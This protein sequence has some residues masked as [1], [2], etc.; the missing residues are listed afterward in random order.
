MIYPRPVS[1]ASRRRP[2]QIEHLESRQLLAADCALPPGFVSTLDAPI[3]PAETISVANAEPGSNRATAL[4]LGIVNETVTL[5]D[6]VSFRDRL[7]VFRFEISRDGTAEIDLSR[8]RRNADLLL[9]DASG[10]ALESARSRGRASESISAEL[11][12]GVYYV[13]V[14]KRSFRGTL[15]RLDIDVTLG[16]AAPV[17]VN[18][19]TPGGG[20]STE[21][22]PTETNPPSATP[23]GGSTSPLSDAA[24]FG[25]SREWNVNAVNAPEAWQAG[26]TG[27]GVTIAVVDTGVDL[28]H[29]DL[30]DRLYVN[31]GEI[32][33]NGIDDDG[34]GFI[35]DVHGFDFAGRDGDPND[36]GGHGTHVAGSIAAGRN[37]FGAT[38][39][40]PD[41]TILPVRVLG[42]NGSGSTRDVAAGIRYAADR[43]ADIINLSL[44]GGYSR[45][46]QS[47]I[48]YARSLGAFIVAAAGNESA[49]TP[50]Y[51]ARFS[52][53]YDNVISVGAHDQSNR[54]ARF[55]N[56]VGGSGA[57]QIDGPGVGVFSTYVGA[58]YGSLSGTSMAAPH[59]AGVA[60]LAL[61]ANPNL[62]PDQLRG[63]LVAGAT[64]SATGSD[65]VGIVN[66]ATTVAYAAAGLTSPPVAVASTSDVSGLSG[67]NA[68]YYRV[69]SQP[70]LIVSATRLSESTSDNESNPIL[71]ESAVMDSTGSEK[72]SSYAASTKTNSPTAI[73]LALHDLQHEAD[74]DSDLVDR[75]L[76]SLSSPIS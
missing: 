48:E 68:R 31:A 46:I 59:V 45:A 39:I 53:L 70:A 58:R 21:T 14:Q 73:D 15:Y 36:V 43:G 62:T 22:D 64:A 4:D 16:S 11:E 74:S 40:A 17:I 67:A 25:G 8:L 61:S 54:L 28:D 19:T 5:T 18:P 3:A 49:G 23:S 26:F 35:D 1:C 50:G 44:G 76:S 6:R 69:I 29:P 12:S 9:F 42:A 51:P 47:A 63:L 27:Q 57:V 7:D 34:N 20:G 71:I 66:A 24:Y 56:D 2:I 33:G 41:A 37:G 75:A 60:A 32:S 65:A 13:A 72:V 30:V 10:S 38:G 52:S 55:S